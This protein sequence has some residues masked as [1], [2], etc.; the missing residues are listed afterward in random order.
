MFRQFF[1]Q[2]VRAFICVWGCFVYFGWLG[3]M[4]NSQAT[5]RRAA[6]EGRGGGLSQGV[7]PASYGRLKVA[8]DSQSHGYALFRAIR[9]RV[10]G[11]HR[12]CSILLLQTGILLQVDRCV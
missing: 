3:V 7:L 11:L 2:K 8:Y 6:V 1:N 5:N 12:V 9:F 10:N 4:Y